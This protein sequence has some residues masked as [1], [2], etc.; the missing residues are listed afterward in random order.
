MRRQGEGRRML[1]VHLI[2]CWQL[3]RHH[4]R[5]FIRRLGCCM[6][7]GGKGDIW[8]LKKGKLM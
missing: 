8:R 2:G 4:K 7:M 5:W 1:M 6:G 3:L